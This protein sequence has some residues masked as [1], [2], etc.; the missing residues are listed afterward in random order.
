MGEKLKVF[1]QGRFFMPGC[2]GITT[3]R[4]TDG[5]ELFSNPEEFRAPVKKLIGAVK[6]RYGERVDVSVVNSWGFFSLWD[7]VRLGIKPSVPTWVMNSRKIHEG[8]P[9]QDGL[10]EAID[11]EL[12]R[13]S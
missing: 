11:A 3:L 6:E 10:F 7:V 4:G 9:S 1:I 12:S 8:V 5:E 13:A 2:C